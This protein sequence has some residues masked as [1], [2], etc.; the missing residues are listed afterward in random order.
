M[1]DGRGTQ[2]CLDIPAAA[3]YAKNQHVFVLNAVD[4]DIL[5]NWK[6][7]HSGRQVLVAGTAEVW[8]L[9]QQVIGR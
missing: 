3:Q 1:T 4:D 5:P 9:C 7:R 2:E 8:M 6:A